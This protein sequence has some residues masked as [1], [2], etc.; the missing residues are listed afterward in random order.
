L[1]HIYEDGD[2]TSAKILGEAVGGLQKGG[3]EE[4]K[5]EREVA[6]ERR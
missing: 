4:S 6:G 2:V 1:P 3:R 5:M